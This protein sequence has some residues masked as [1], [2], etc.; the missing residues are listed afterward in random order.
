MNEPILFETFW[1]NELVLFE[2]FWG[3]IP[4]RRTL[5]KTDVKKDGRHLDAFQKGGR[6]RLSFCKSD[7]VTSVFFMKMEDSHFLQNQKDRRHRKTT[8][9][10]V[11]KL[12]CKM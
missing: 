2:T 11:S 12:F 10:N 3:Q 5:E 6:R 9:V 4:K 7:R 1:D 8:S